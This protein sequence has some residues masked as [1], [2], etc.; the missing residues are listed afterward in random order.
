LLEAGAQASAKRLVIVT[1]DQ[2]QTL[3]QNGE[4]IEVLPAWE[5][6]K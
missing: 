2:K 1:F 6:L 5:W 4:K 3:S